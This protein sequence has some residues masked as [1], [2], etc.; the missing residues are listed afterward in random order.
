MNFPAN[1]NIT[2]Y[3][4]TSKFIGGAGSSAIF[5]VAGIWR[6]DKTISYAKFGAVRAAW[7]RR[8]TMVQDKTRPA[9][10]AMK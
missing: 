8:D 2:Y 4:E 6:N 7:L 10:K 3:A 9:K 5:D 1:L